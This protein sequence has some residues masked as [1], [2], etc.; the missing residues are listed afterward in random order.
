[1]YINFQIIFKTNYASNLWPNNFIHKY[2]PRQ[3]KTCLH[4]RLAFNCL[5]HSNQKL[6]TAQTHYNR[7]NKQVVVILHNEVL[8]WSKK[9]QHKWILKILFWVRGAK[10]RVEHMHAILFHL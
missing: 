7:M 5:I 4:K 10:Y 8:L 2:L 9:K 1:M 3:M 6:E